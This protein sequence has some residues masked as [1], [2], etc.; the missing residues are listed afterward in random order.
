MGAALPMPGPWHTI[1]TDRGIYIIGPSSSL[2]AIVQPYHSNVVQNEANARLIASAPDLLEAL[3]LLEREM[4]LS[5]NAESLD[6]GWLPA[7]T[8]TRAAIARA[9]GEAA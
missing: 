4:V 8:K 2:L 7:I 5:G 9:T 3:I 6:Y 1:D